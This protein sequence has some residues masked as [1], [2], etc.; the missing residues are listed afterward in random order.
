M[1]VK[2]SFKTHSNNFVHQKT[3][4]PDHLILSVQGDDI[5][6]VE[7]QQVPAIT[8]FEVESINNKSDEFL[9]TQLGLASAGRL[10]WQEQILRQVPVCEVH[11]KFK[12]SDHILFVYGSNHNVW[13]D[14]Y[15]T[16]EFFWFHERKL[17]LES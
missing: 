11:Y 2:I 5:H 15:S 4:L 1:A 12:E 3:D 8:A 17:N 14:E 10:V 13:F 9:T 16:L 7:G 6:Y